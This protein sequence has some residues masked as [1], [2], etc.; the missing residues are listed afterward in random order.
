MKEFNFQLRPEWIQD[1]EDALPVKGLFYFKIITNIFNFYINYDF[2]FLTEYPDE[3]PIE[4]LF[5]KLP[6]QSTET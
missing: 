1:Y 2:L 3:T 5:M 6:L 4:Q